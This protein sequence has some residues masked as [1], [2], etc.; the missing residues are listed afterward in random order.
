M[1]QSYSQIERKRKIEL[2]RALQN[3]DTNEVQRLRELTAKQ[4][5]CI[6]FMGNEKIGY[7]CQNPL[8]NKL[9][10]RQAEKVGEDYEKVTFFELLDDE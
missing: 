2:V 5:K 4:G 9:T 1:K 10:K 8:L 7:N 6:L 3:N